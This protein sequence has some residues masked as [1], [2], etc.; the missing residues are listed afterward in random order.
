MD[1]NE[2]LEMFSDGVFAIAI[3]ILV[4]D[5]KVPPLESVHSTADVW[6]D[7][8]R[9]WPSFFAL[10]LSFIFILISWLGHFNLVK[11]LNGTSS[12]FQMANG[13][14][15][16]TVI[17]IPF[18]TAF[19]AEYLNTTFAQPAIV[20]YCLMALLHNI[21][22]N[23]LYLSIVRPVLFVEDAKNLASLKMGR[24]GAKTGF[25]IYLAIALLALWLPY[26][27]IIISFLIWI[28]WLYLSISIKQHGKE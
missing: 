25:L 1:L 4:L 12:K 28:Y 23:V 7:I 19:M 21:G 26:I 5:M 24:Q 22:W 13:F 16:F 2:R 15:L 9:L 10:C 27:A 14:F 20:I 11:M 8:I 18:P 3:T 17:F 6:Q